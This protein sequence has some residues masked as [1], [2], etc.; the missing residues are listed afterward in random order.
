MIVQVSNQLVQMQLANW[1]IIVSDGDYFTVWQVLG[2]LIA[3][4]HDVIRG[5]VAQI[6]DLL[7]NNSLNVQSA[8]ANT[9]G[10]LAEHCK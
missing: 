6:V 7:K 10:R 3:T 9:I 5:A 1:L 2:L 4:F 8:G